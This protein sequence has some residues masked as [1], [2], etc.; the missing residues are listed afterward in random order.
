MMHKTDTS[1]KGVS[2]VWVVILITI[3]MIIVAAMTSATVKDLQMTTGADLSAQAFGA[4]KAGIEAN[5]DPNCANTTA[6]TYSIDAKTSY[7]VTLRA[8]PPGGICDVE[9]VGTVGGVTRKLKQRV[10][11]QTAPTDVIVFPDDID[12]ATTAYSTMTS[13]TDKN[14]YMKD[15]TNAKDNFTQQ[16]DVALGASPTFE[17]IGTGDGT[18]L[19][20]VGLESATRLKVFKSTTVGNYSTITGSTMDINA[21]P[22]N[23]TVRFVIKYSGEVFG[24]KIMDTN[25]ICLAY[26]D[27]GAFANY[28]FDK[29]YVADLANAAPYNSTSGYLQNMVFNGVRYTAKTINYAVDPP[30]SGTISGTNPQYITRNP[31]GS[32]GDGSTVSAVANRGYAFVNWSDGNTN[33]TRTD[34]N[35]TESAQLVANFRPMIN[36][37]SGVMT[38][39]LQTSDAI[40]WQAGSVNALA[41]SGVN[42]NTPG[43]SVNSLNMVGSMVGGCRNTNTSGDAMFKKLIYIPPGATTL[44]FDAAGGVYTGSAST[45]TYND[46]IGVHIYTGDWITRLARWDAD[47]GG[48]NTLD[49]ARPNG[50]PM[51]YNGWKTYSLDVSSR[52]G[53][54]LYFYAF[55]HIGCWG[56]SLLLDNI[57]V[58]VPN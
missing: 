14:G 24:V 20:M 27:L 28:K 56:S 29:I 8:V 18:I 1:N 37:D 15:G 40:Y 10:T 13:M 7:T 48:V 49:S 43:G 17:P 32:G 47:S 54:S 9:S 19:F 6:T 57:Q 55:A 35:I 41:A 23:T 12:N 53:Q 50:A 26:K 45:L 21:L 22:A 52:G 4:A 16:F 42:W 33:A 38:D 46:T 34:T 5:K 36:F 11:A 25:G 44:T 2:L 30:G 51:R 3:V 39:Y 58:N 31:D